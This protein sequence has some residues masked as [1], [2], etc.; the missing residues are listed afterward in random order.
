MFAIIYYV[1]VSLDGYIAT[2]DGGVKWLA[3]FE[4]SGED[5][6]YAKFYASVDAVLVGRRTF[7]QSQSFADV[8]FPGK[9]CWVFSR[10]HSSGDHAGVKVTSES[11]K[12][13]ATELEKQGVR[14]AWLVGGGQLAGAFQAERLISE[15]IISVMPVVLGAGIQLFRPSGSTASL[16]LI[17]SKPFSSGVVQLTYSRLT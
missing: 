6:N 10:S 2:P 1:A 7:E 4:S 17:E 3:H 14:R 5:Y 15:Y 9:S 11:P 16:K 13:V 12:T 8:P